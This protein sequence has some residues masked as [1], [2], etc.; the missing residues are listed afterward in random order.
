QGK[1]RLSSVPHFRGIVMDRLCHR[2]WQRMR[3]EFEPPGER[4]FFLS[5]HAGF[6]YLLFNLSNPTP[7]DIPIHPALGCGGEKQLILAL[8]EQEL[9][10]I[11]DHPYWSNWWQMNTTRRP[12]EL[13]AFIESQMVQKTDG[14]PGFD[15]IFQ[16]FTKR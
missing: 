15:T 12:Y 16:I 2:H 9:R 8:Q 11:R 4:V 3:R 14:V 6:Y 5:T 1:T 10:V 7:F 13:E